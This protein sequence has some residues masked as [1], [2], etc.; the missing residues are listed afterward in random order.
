MAQRFFG[1][2]IGGVVSPVLEFVDVD[3]VLQRIDVNE[4]VQR[5]DFDTLLSKIDL[6]RLLDSVDIDRQISRVDLDSLVKRSN[7]EAIIARS[8]TSIFTALFD[9][10]RSNV[11]VIDQYIQRSARFSCC[12]SRLILP[13]YP[14]VRTRDMPWPSAGVHRMGVAVQGRCAGT[15]SRFIGTIIDLVIISLSFALVGLI[16]R[17][18]LEKVGMDEDWEPEAKWLIPVLYFIYWT[19]YVI[20]C[21][22]LTG[23]TIGGA[24]FGLLLVRSNGHRAGFFQICLRTY[25]DPFNRIFFGW[26]LGL[27]RRDGSQ[28]HD[29]ISYTRVVYSWDARAASIREEQ[30]E[31]FARSALIEIQS[32]DLE[33]QEMDESHHDE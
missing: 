32:L 19:S 30:E 6:D 16:L 10:L 4:L 27:L 5:I 25:L 11:C 9:L 8:S 33:S 21:T 12:K 29:L 1:H 13:P 7:L 17:W 15:L 3:G 28:Y 14:G 31:E 22:A 23:R 24:I 26:I 18:F 2:A 20:V